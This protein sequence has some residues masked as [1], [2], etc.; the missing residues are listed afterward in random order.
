MQLSQ[1]RPWSVAVHA[2]FLRFLAAAA[3]AAAV[4]GSSSASSSSSAA[5]G[6]VW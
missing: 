5:A 6:A 3:A 1:K 2:A 4:A